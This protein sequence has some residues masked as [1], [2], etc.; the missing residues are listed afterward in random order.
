MVPALIIPT[1][2]MALTP[3]FIGPKAATTQIYQ[4]KILPG[5]NILLDEEMLDLLSGY[6]NRIHPIER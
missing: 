3:S 1:F 6:G 2:I 4:T 5:F